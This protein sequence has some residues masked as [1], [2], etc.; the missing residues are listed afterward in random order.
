[1]LFCLA[2]LFIVYIIYA[3]V[4]SNIIIVG[5]LLYTL[6]Y[7]AVLSILYI[8]YTFILSSINDSDNDNNNNAQFDIVI[9]VDGDLTICLD[10]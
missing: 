1:M 3:F 8:I 7:L 10:C 5:Y 4:L 9:A 2:V 6:L